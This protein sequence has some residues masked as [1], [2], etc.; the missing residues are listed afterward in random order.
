MEAIPG[1]R[2]EP[3]TGL[4]VGMVTTEALKPQADAT[5]WAIAYS[6]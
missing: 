5:D 1:T 3:G 2:H 4:L 6:H